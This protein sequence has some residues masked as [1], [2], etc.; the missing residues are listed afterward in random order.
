M[1]IRQRRE[2]QKLNESIIELVKSHT[3]TEY[4]VTKVY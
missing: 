3:T 2:I 1:E 4:M